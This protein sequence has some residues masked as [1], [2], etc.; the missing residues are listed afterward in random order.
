MY[1]IYKE[2]LV[3]TSLE[4]AWDFIRNPANLNKIT[5]DDMAFEIVSDMPENMYEGMLV[6]YRVKIPG[7]GTQAW[8]SEL[9]HIMP[10]RS[11]VD[12]QKIGPYKLWYHYHGIE[13]VDG[14]VKFIDRVTYEVPFW[15][16]GK[17]AH[18]LFISKTLERIFAYREER[19][20]SLLAD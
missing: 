3:D 7:M 17:I 12:E 16:F 6:Q 9:K 19:F 18:A 13:A 11:F 8:L 2:T 4:K 1:T 15:I 5:P 10:G 20:Q 14:G